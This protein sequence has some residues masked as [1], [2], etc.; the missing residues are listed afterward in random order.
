MYTCIQR[1]NERKGK[2]GEM[3]SIAPFYFLFF[4]LVGAFLAEI[5][6]RIT[7]PPPGT[8]LLPHRHP[9]RHRRND[10]LSLG[11][12]QSLTRNL[13]LF[14]CNAQPPRRSL[15]SCAF[16]LFCYSK[17]PTHPAPCLPRCY[18]EDHCRPAVRRPPVAQ[19]THPAPCF[20][21]RYC[22]DLC[23]SAV[24]RPPVAPNIYFFM[25]FRA[26]AVPTTVLLLFS[27]RSSGFDINEPRFRAL[28]RI[29]RLSTSTRALA[30]LLSRSPL[31]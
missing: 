10:F 3:S 18:C 12:P 6:P 28:S 13:V 4:I 14:F 26:A 21:R 2:I 7:R 15:C 19:P 5:H 30:A 25:L 16:A 24:P 8:V 9:L 11:P 17:K 20:P 27:D 22:E 23:R 29:L 1:T 31:Y